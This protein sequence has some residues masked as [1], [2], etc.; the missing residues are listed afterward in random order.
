VSVSTSRAMGMY[1][2]IDSLLED[3]CRFGSPA[4]KNCTRRSKASR[5]SVFSTDK[6]PWRD[7]ASRASRRAIQIAGDWAQSRLD[8]RE[9][10]THE[11]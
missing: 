7:E 4:K 11:D 3:M 10:S 2:E 1:M 6:S 8:V 9:G 5:R